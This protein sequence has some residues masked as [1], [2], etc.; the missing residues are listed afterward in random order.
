M[1]KVINLLRYFKSLEKYD[2]KY[3]IYIKDKSSYF[4]KN[5]TIIALSLY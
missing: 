4:K 5:K 3:L 2:S 1:K